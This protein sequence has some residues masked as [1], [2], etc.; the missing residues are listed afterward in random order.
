MKKTVNVPMSAV[1]AVRG[2][3]ESKLVL[4]M[5]DDMKAAA[6]KAANRKNMS[7][8]AWIRSA[9]FEALERK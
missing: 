3:I 1:R 2:S 4:G 8:V 6:L 9:I 5:S 7:L